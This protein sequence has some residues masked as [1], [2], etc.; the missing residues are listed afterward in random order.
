[1]EVEADTL[2]L[3]VAL[4]LSLRVQIQVDLDLVETLSWQETLHLQVLLKE[5]QA[6]LVLLNPHQLFHV[7][8]AA[9]LEQQA[10]Q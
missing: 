1:V 9:V 8:V 6:D 4:L 3:V 5:T 7:A 2:L 10:E